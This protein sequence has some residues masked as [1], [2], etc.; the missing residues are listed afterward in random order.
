MG[1][2]IEPDAHAMLRDL[3]GQ[4]EAGVLKTALPVALIPLL[5][6]VAISLKRIADE[7]ERV[8]VTGTPA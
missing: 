3:V 5:A 2:S 8:K 4:A 1:Q 7:M 6:S